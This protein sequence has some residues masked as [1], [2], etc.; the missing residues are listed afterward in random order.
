MKPSDVIKNKKN[1][2]KY[3]LATTADGMPCHPKSNKAASFCLLGACQRAEALDASVKIIYNNIRREILKVA[4]TSDNSKGWSPCWRSVANF[5]DSDYT[6][7]KKVL[8]VLTKAEANCRKKNKA[9]IK[10]LKAKKA[11]AELKKF[12]KQIQKG[13]NNIHELTITS[14]NKKKVLA[15]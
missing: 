13:F 11:R 10:R 7:H 12:K 9:A 14:T 1:W 2:C 3:T 4:S 8:N 6:S 5:N 15:G